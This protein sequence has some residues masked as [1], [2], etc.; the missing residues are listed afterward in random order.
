MRNSSCYIFIVLVALLQFTSSPIWAQ[1]RHN[2]SSLS[3]SEIM[4]GEKF[5]GYLPENISW[6]PNNRH[7]LFSWNPEKEIIRSPFRIAID[8]GFEISRL[9]PEEQRVTPS[10]GDYNRDRTKMV[11]SK[12]GDLFLYR[13]QTDSIERLSR[14]HSG[15][16]HPQFT[17]D[18]KGVIYRSGN[19]LF[20]RSLEKLYEE[21][22]VRFESGSKS[23][24]RSLSAEEEWLKRDQLELF[25]VLRH[26]RNQKEMRE[27]RSEEG[28]ES[29]IYTIYLE[30]KT[31][32]HQS[33]CP[34]M[35]F[36]GFRLTDNPDMNYTDVPNYVTESGQVDIIRSRP[37]IGHPQ[38]GFEF[39][40]Y[41]MKRDTHYTVRTEDLPD[42][43][44]KPEFLLEYDAEAG[45]EYEEDRSVVVLGPHYSKSGKAF[46]VVRS[47]DNKDRW[48]AKLDLVSGEL[49]VIDHQRDEAWIGGPGIGGWNF[50]EG[51]VGWLKDDRHIYFQ[52]E[53]SGYS[54]LYLYDTEEKNIRALTAG[55]WEV[56]D[57]E[58]SH[59]GRT[60]YLTA[61]AEGPHEHHFYH[62]DIESKEMVRV[63][64]E[65]GGHQISMSPDQK[66]L[67]IRYSYSN[68]P[69]ELYYMPN[70][71]GA[72]M[73]RLTHSTTERFNAYEWKTPEIVNFEARDGADVPARLYLPE[74]SNGA[75]VIFVH[76]AGYLQNVHHWWS[77]YFR[78]YM[79]HNIL[80]DNG[81]TVLDID[82]RASAGYGRDWRTAIYRH[83]GGVD[84]TDQVDG[85][86]W[87]VQHRGIDADK[88]GIYGGSY[89][90]FIS[91]MAM[92]LEGET[93]SAAA[94]LRSVTDW[95]HYNHGY[96]SN[97]L[98]T[99]VE[100][101][102]AYHRSSPIYHAKGLEGPLLMLHGVID[103]NVQFQD[104][105]RLSQRLIELGKEDWDLALYPLEDHGFI[106]GSS[107]SD[108]YRRIFYWFEKHLFN[109]N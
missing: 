40:I 71:K 3:I 2:H 55:E 63:T 47:M 41:D 50:M 95:A 21:Q 77:S 46:V 82:F 1:E 6:H 101:S 90:G 103:V 37:K 78:E 22:L 13:V 18:E 30:G 84:L 83:M 98:N 23:S 43:R 35:R 105:V 104:V 67:A 94:A 102:L 108:E 107:W 49:N 85:A 65:K 109:R 16:H 74:T 59:D 79:F 86:E 89:G 80:T 10:S 39:W 93:F 5:I 4:K 29:G 7:I 11:Y 68:L 36:V 106:E 25:D 76:G 9:S 15:K 27:Q 87:L 70:E 56:I 75:A 60:F 57:L 12:E 24:E 48:I 20:Y 31:V 45:R 53:I 72:E 54:H 91:I 81:Y 64:H 96:T 42:I 66:H 19:H 100:D 44:K 38:P 51:N 73:K 61:N 99:P 69:W 97:I 8:E 58:L 34:N 14:T 92:F 52:S 88:I 26:R 32:S 28:K 17:S 62:L 33:V